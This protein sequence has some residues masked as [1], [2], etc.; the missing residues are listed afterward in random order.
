MDLDETLLQP[1]PAV[2]GSAIIVNRIVFA[3]SLKKR[4]KLEHDVFLLFG[5]LS[6]L[7]NA[8]SI[9]GLSAQYLEV[10]PLPI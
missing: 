6:I 5:N 7:W 2:D 3:I 4:S 9:F 1:V 8:F 10:Y